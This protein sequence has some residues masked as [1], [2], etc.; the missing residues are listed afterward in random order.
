VAREALAAGGISPFTDLSANVLDA[1][2]TT[3]REQE[4]AAVERLFELRKLES[5]TY[6]E[7]ERSGKKVTKGYDDMMEAVNN[8]RD[9]LWDLFNLPNEMNFTDTLKGQLDFSIAQAEALLSKHAKLRGDYS[10]LPGREI[11]TRGADISGMTEEKEIVRALEIQYQF[12]KDL[13][14]TIWRKES[15]SGTGKKWLDYN[16]IQGNIKTQ[17]RGPFQ[18]GPEVFSRGQ[19]S[20]YSRR[21]RQR[22]TPSRSS[23]NGGHRRFPV[24]VLYAWIYYEYVRGLLRWKS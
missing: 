6:K 22:K 18:I 2:I 14:T 5:D 15:G 20:N 11:S 3:T 10:S 16:E 17:I 13:L 4:L 8:L 24:W 7:L 23:R 21:H 12:P 19:R 9:A 1:S